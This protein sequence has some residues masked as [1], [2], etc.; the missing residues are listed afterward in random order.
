MKTI[1]GI[2]ALLFFTLTLQSQEVKTITSTDEYKELLDNS[3][4][5]VVLVN[6]WATWCPPCVKEFPELV[7]LYNDYK[8]KDFVLLFI[9]L[10][11]KSEYDSKLLP[12]LKKQGVD[13]TSYF[14]NFSNPET[15]MNYVDK[16]WQGEIPFTGIYNK[17]GIL[18]KTLMGNKTYEQ[19]ETEIKKYM[20]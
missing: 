7:K 16:S 11:D 2:I 13:F 12:F 4:G 8:S 17:D 10:D 6:F 9:S 3:K 19:F 5:K 14:G 15:I 1:A 18:S 20:D